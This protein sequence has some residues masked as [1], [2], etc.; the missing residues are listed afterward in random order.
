MTPAIRHAVS[1]IAVA[2]IVFLCLHLFLWGTVSTGPHVYLYL[3]WLELHRYGDSW[4]I[5]HLHLG[6][7]LAVLLVSVLLSMIVRRQFT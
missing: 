1:F 4:T 2:V 7:L 6:G 3:G 5:E